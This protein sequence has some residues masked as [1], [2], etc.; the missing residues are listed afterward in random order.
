MHVLDQVNKQF[1][2]RLLGIRVGDQVS[3]PNSDNIRHNVY[4]FSPAK[5]FELP[6]YRGI[7]CAPITFDEAGK[8][9]LGCNIHDRMSAP[10]YVVDTDL[11]ATT[12]NGTHTFTALSPG[13]YD[14][15]VFQLRQSAA[16]DGLRR[17]LTVT[18]DGN[19][20]ATIS[21]ALQAEKR[22][23]APHYRRRN[24]NSTSCV[25]ARPSFRRRIIA[26]LVVALGFVQILTLA[27][28]LMATHR[29][30]QREIK[31]NLRVAE[32]VFERL[33]DAR[34]RQLIGSVQVLAADFGFKQAVATADADTIVSV[35]DNHGA[36]A[37]AEMPA[38]APASFGSSL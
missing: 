17:P 13:E 19:Q 22:P 8:V 30:V 33:F 25:M 18:A 20:L 36:R 34:F 31:E 2:P 10:I 23:K 5:K 14:I 37:N 26:L 15:A 7:P 29:N 11:L 4:S 28:V 35:L 1:A 3:F 32:S 9:V 27:A 12:D 16:D 24:A 6:L 38:T 21:S